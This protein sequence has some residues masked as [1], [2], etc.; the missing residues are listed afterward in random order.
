MFI[1]N[2][3]VGLRFGTEWVAIQL[4]KETVK[5]ICF[6]FVEN[7]YRSTELWLPKTVLK[8][9]IENKAKTL[10]VGTSFIKNENNCQNLYFAM[11]RFENSLK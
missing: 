10:T 1:K 9:T 11:K 8:E 3:I 2:E 6:K 5:A 7:E 4:I